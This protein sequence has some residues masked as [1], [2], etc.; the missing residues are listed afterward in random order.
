M[1]FDNFTVTALV[2][3]ALFLGLFSKYCLP[4]FYVM[5]GEQGHL[6]E[7]GRDEGNREARS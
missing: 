4:T 5:P 1:Y 2:V 7:T 6:T 3:F